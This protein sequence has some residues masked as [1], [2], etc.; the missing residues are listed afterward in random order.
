MTY[1][2]DQTGPVLLWSFYTSILV[3]LEMG[4]EEGYNLYFVLTCASVNSS[5]QAVRA[6]ATATYVMVSS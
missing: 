2:I 1:Y 6:V 3:S 5:V 4:L